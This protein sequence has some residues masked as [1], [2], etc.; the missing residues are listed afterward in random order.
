MAVATIV[1]VLVGT[2][3][4]AA[5]SA[6]GGVTSSAIRIGVPYIDFSSLAAEGVKLTQGSFPDAYGALI[7]NMNAHGGVNGRKIVAYYAPVNLAKGTVGVDA[8]CTTLTEDHTIFLAMAPYEPNCYVVNHSTPTINATFEGAAPVASAPN[9]T[10]TPPANAYDPLQLTVYDKM[11]LFRGKKVTVTG[12]T[13][14]ASEVRVVVAT[15]EKLHVNVVQTAINSAAVGDQTALIAQDQIIVQRFQNA[16]VSEVVAAGAASGGWPQGLS[17]L[18]ASY[19]PPWV[20]MED[21]SLSGVLAE[22]TG[23][24]KYLRMV[25]TSTPTPTSAGLQGP[26]N[27]EVCRHHQEGLSQRHHHSAEPDIQ[28]LRSQLHRTAVGVS[29]PGDLR[30]HR[31]GRRK[32]LDPG[33]LHQG[34]LRPPERLVPWLRWARLLRSQAGLRDRTRLRRQVQR[35]P[36]P[37][38][39]LA[40]ACRLVSGWQTEL[41]W[42]D[43]LDERCPRRLQVPLAVTRA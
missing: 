29:E 42:S 35:S 1:V 25:T 37:A 32:E 24:A 7:A 11:G 17:Q 31:Q 9:F 34:W 14:D 33:Q 19:N 18:Q 13:A 22:G 3:G 5:A 41:D 30:H 8:V 20:A 10:L 6:N 26:R 23:E 16:G 2:A 28:Q 43:R 4:L 21:S 27:P 38:R 12:Q 40:H 36:E 15:L 39:V